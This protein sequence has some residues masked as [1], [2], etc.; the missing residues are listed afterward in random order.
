MKNFPSIITLC[1]ILISNY[2]FCQF[3]IINNGGGNRFIQ[4]IS[5][6]NNNIIINGGYNCLLKCYNN[7]DT[8]FSLIPPGNIGNVNYNI[9]RS[10]SDTIFILSSNFGS[11]ISTLYKSTNG[12]QSW[13][14]IFTRTNMIFYSIDMI[15][16]KYGVIA[17]WLGTNFETTDGGQNWETD[18]TGLFAGYDIVEGFGDSTFY[19]TSTGFIKRTTDLFQTWQDGSLNGFYGVGGLH[20]L[21]KDTLLMCAT[22]N[23]QNVNSMMSYS[24]DGGINWVKKEISNLV[25]LNDVYFK[26]KNEGYIVGYKLGGVN[27]GVILKTTDFGQSFTEIITPYNVEFT[28]IEFI[29]DSIA[30]L[31]A[32]NGLLVQWNTKIPITTSTSK[33]E[34][35]TNNLILYPN[36]SA[37]N[38][39]IE[40]RNNNLKQLVIYNSIGQKIKEIQNPKFVSG[41][42]NIDTE[43]LFSGFYFVNCIS[44]NGE[45]ET[46]KFIKSN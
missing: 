46:L 7:C 5:V 35:Q 22:G 23:A 27:K 33:M 44:I 26:N 6:V 29:N 43:N 19:M 1:F 40:S 2:S 42:I 20:I 31:G 30:L 9:C 14:G 12:G 13:E 24:I 21:N 38:I 36:P 37:N 16:N 32:S 4:D 34:S 17:G 41:K 8:V 3:K 11:S 45:I 10:D 25:Y 28:K 39:T 18:S 15:K